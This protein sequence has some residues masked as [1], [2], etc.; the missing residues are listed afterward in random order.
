MSTP[1]FLVST[2]AALKPKTE[3]DH[4][5]CRELADHLL[6]L[7]EEGILNGLTP[8][9][10]ERDALAQLR[11]PENL[12]RRIRRA[13]RGS[14]RDIFRK[15]LLPGVVSAIPL[16]IFGLIL[17]QYFGLRSP[18]YFFWGHAAFVFY[19]YM[20]PAFGVAGFLGAW[21][22]RQQGGSVR[23]RILA[24]MFLA[25]L[26]FCLFT[27][28]LPLAYVV[29]RHV[30]ITLMMQAYAGY[31]LSQVIVPGIPMLLGTL[32]L[33]FSRKETVPQDPAMA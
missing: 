12:R 6:E 4:E 11:S 21:H 26:N 27:L 32:P 28:P 25:I 14:M 8:E 17:E 13:Q 15:V 10:A 29:D 19:W 22:S 16:G 7:H 20:M 23:D 30:P 1:D 5:T 33:L 9:L 18:A 24:G 2:R 3:R 31:M